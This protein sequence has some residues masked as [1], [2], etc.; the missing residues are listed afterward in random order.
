MSMSP[1]AAPAVIGRPR[2]ARRPP[3]AEAV[4]QVRDAVLVARCRRLFRLL[5]VLLCGLHAYLSRQ[6]MTADGLAYLNAADAYLRDDT[7][8]ALRAVG[9]PLYSWLLAGVFGVVRP[10]AARAAVVV[11][12]V[13]F[14]VFLAAL[15]AFEWLLSELL[16]CRRAAAAAARA[17]WQEVV[18]DWCVVGL[19]YAFFALVSRRLTS[20]AAVSPDLLVSAVVY[21][22]AALLLRFRRRGPTPAAALLFGTLLALGYLARPALLPSAAVFLA[23]SV[24]AARSPRGAC[25]HLAWSV[26]AFTALAAPFVVALSLT[27]GRANLGDGAV[28]TFVWHFGALGRAAA[29]YADVIGGRVLCYTGALAVLF[30]Y[31]FFSQR[32]SVRGWLGECGRLLCRQYALLLP[33][34]AALGLALPDGHGDGGPVG[35]FLVLAALT[36][37]ESLRFRQPQLPHVRPLA[38][39]LVTCLAVALGVAAALDVKDVAAAAGAFSG[40]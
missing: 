12:A 18:P 9:G 26:F 38:V 23:V 20:A 24:A 33:A 25:R 15:A 2:S 16:R 3:A 40:G 4:P 32:R 30:G 39:T 19:A 7:A 27:T 5:A 17:R 8:T 36:L 14:A 21:G 6:A 1:P 31:V 13:N 37:P 29:F 22:A 35:P 10:G 11:H 28:P 34:L